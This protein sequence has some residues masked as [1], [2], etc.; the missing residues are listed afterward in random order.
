MWYSFEGVSALLAK[1]SWYIS[2]LIQRHPYS[3]SGN[4][5]YFS[6]KLLLEI[7]SWGGYGADICPFFR[8]RFHL[9]ASL[10]SPVTLTLQRKPEGIRSGEPSLV[11]LVSCRTWHHRTR[12]AFSSATTLFFFVGLSIF[13]M[14]RSAWRRREDNDRVQTT[15]EGTLRRTQGQD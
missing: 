14:W 3:T 6:L 13:I 4:R 5:T 2:K 12:P 1:L 11:A 9:S 15:M 7:N 10:P 8:Q